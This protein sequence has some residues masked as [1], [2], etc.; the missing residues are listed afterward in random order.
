MAHSI[1]TGQ[2]FP[3]FIPVV[4]QWAHEQG[5]HRGRAEVMR[6]LSHRDFHSGRPGWLQALLSV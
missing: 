6:G 4:T 3:S 1:D 2:P 5:D